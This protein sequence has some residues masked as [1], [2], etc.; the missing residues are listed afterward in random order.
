MSDHVQGSKLAVTASNALWSAEPSDVPFAHRGGQKPRAASVLA[1]QEGA[2]LRIA[3]DWVRPCVR[4]V[5]MDKGFDEAAGLA[6]A[7]QSGGVVQIDASDLGQLDTL[8]CL[9]LADLEVALAAGGASVEMINLPAEKNDL[10]Q[11]VRSRAHVERPQ[12]RRFALD[13]LIA[14]FGRGVVAT[15]DDMLGVLSMMGLVLVSVGTT[16]VNPQRW[17]FNAFV[18]QLDKSAFRA[19]PIIVLIQF[20]IGGIVAQQSAFQLRFFGAEIFTINL[21]AILVLREIGVLI[22]AIMVAGRTG[23][24]FTAEIG[25]MRMREEVDAMRVIGLDPV[26][27][28]V[29][30]RILGLVIALPLLTIIANA[31]ALLG[32]LL[33]LWVY[34]GI[35]PAVFID[36][37]HGAI[38]LNTVMVGLI[39]APFMAIAIGCIACMEGFRVSGSTESLGQHVTS[40]VV[41]SIFAVIVLDGIFAIFF[42]AINY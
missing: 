10:Y 6:P 16:L 19:V 20:V 42:A 31:S 27:V 23:S 8:G 1:G 7:A 28:L 26:D 15:W 4:D 40:A 41:K 30:P 17:R 18:T 5:L 34:S 32:G 13:D 21:V 14:A 9:A 35:D 39:K 25:A 38:A 37:M 2:A 36:R 29:V 24:A 33:V 12:R 11:A 22:S 3:G